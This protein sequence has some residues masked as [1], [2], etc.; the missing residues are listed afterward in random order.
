MSGNKISVESVPCSRREFLVTEAIRD[1]VVKLHDICKHTGYN[2]ATV[3]EILMEFKT[4]GWVIHNHSKHTY[5]IADG[6]TFKQITRCGTM[7]EQEKEIRKERS[8][9]EAKHKQ[10]RNPLGFVDTSVKVYHWTPE[11]IAEHEQKLRTGKVF[12]TPKKGGVDWSESG[13]HFFRSG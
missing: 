11:Q 12:A 3:M 8:E 1:G 7:R 2:Y 5:A 10:R 9:L 6:M 13:H 4:V